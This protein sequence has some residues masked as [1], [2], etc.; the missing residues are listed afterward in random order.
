MF[1]IIADGVFLEKEEYEALVKKASFCPD[2]KDDIFKI[3]SFISKL[4]QPEMGP[5]MFEKYAVMLV[6]IIFISAYEMPYTLTTCL[7]NANV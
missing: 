2:F 7:K 3:R 6:P 5:Q 4:T 1:C